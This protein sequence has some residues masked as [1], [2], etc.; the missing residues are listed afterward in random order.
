MKMLLLLFFLDVTFSKVSP[1][2][3]SQISPERRLEDF[4]NM[5]EADNIRIEALKQKIDKTISKVAILNTIMKNDFDEINLQT[6]DKMNVLKEKIRTFKKDKINRQLNIDLDDESFKVDPE[7]FKEKVNQL[8]EEKKIQKQKL[9][10]AKKEKLEIEK[11]KQQQLE[12]ENKERL[13]NIKNELKKKEEENKQKLEQEYSAFKNKIEEK[14]QESNKIFKEE[15]IKRQEELKKF[16]EEQLEKEKVKKDILEREE[17]EKNALVMVKEAQPITNG[18]E[19]GNQT[20]KGGNGMDNHQEGL[21]NEEGYGNNLKSKKQIVV[22][23]NDLQDIIKDELDK[24]FKRNPNIFKT[25][26]NSPTDII[27]FKI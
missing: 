17:G 5:D 26:E 8:L 20:N 16:E 25:L 12:K 3:S 2:V 19:I 1:K 9:E 18:S 27:N 6:V 23:E 10:E 22:N 24:Y 13:D 14:L 7:T 4:T 11:Q 21:F 15:E